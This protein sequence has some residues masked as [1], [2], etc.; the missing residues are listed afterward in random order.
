MRGYL[1]QILMRDVCQFGQV[2]NY[3]NISAFNN[4]LKPI[5]EAKQHGPFVA[6]IPLLRM[7]S[8]AYLAVL[9]DRAHGLKMEAQQRDQLYSEIVRQIEGEKDLLQEA[10]RE[11]KR[12]G[13]PDGVE[14]HPR[15][16][17]QRAL[18]VFNPAPTDEQCYFC[19]ENFA[20]DDDILQC[21]SNIAHFVHSR[22]LPPRAHRNGC[23]FCR[24]KPFPKRTIK[25]YECNVFSIVDAGKKTGGA[26]YF[27]YQ[28]PVFSII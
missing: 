9:F 12:L 28:L 23:G 18:E 21:D 6:M 19:L 5:I 2:F 4:V 25:F 27:Q 3:S 14:V 20:A 10:E 17:L 7:S 8:L 13:G 26:N 15:S 1:T 22:C 11:R 24:Q 16:W